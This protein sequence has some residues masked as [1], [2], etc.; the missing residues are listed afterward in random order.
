MAFRQLFQLTTFLVILSSFLQTAQADVLDDI[1][2]RDTVRLGFDDAAPFAY[3]SKAG[4]FNGYT[5]EIC[6]RIVEEI[7]LELKKPKLKTEYVQIT[8][9]SRLDKVATG[10]IDLECGATTNNAERRQKVAFAI[11]TFVAGGRMA[12]RKEVAIDRLDQLAGKRVAVTP[13]TSYDDMMN[14][15]VKTK[16]MKINVT[17]AKDDDDGMKLLLDGKVDVT[18]NDDVLLATLLANSGRSADFRIS[19]APL[20]IEPLAIVMKKDNPRLKR[21]ADRVIASLML[22]GEITQL[23]RKWFQTVIPDLSI[24]LNLP[25]TTIMRAYMR[26][27]SDF[28]P[29]VVSY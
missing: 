9:E 16:G 6:Q 24:N 2:Q 19:N 12:M 25:I 28:V 18:L 4:H 13:G 10:A 17:R 20:T 22:S 7:R 8:T 3:K 5:L 23:H 26:A 11:P 14:N 15:L 21:I 27:P 1:R 29:D